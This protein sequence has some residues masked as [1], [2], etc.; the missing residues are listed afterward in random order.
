MRIAVS[1]M[2]TVMLC[3][4]AAAADTAAGPTPLQLY[5]A[6]KY[7]AAI[8]QGTASNAASGYAVA[9]RAELAVAQMRDKPCLECLKTA[10]GYARQSIALD[11]TLADG[12]VYLAAALGYESRIIGIMAAKFKGY[13]GEAKDNLD[14]ALAHHP[15]DPWVLA[16]LGGWHFAV[17]N[18]GG[19]TMANWMYGA[20]VKKGQDYYTK[21]FAADPPGIV[22]RYLYALSLSAYDREAYTKEIEAALAFAATGQPRTAYEMFMQGRAKTLL[23]AFKSGDWKAYNALVKRYQGYP[24]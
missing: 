6:G 17:V 21:A 13:A 12:H 1:A 23:A 4:G 15:D 14:V 16:A 7:A 2:L 3:A 19:A 22:I 11:P 24:Q 20:T 5:Q 10:E 9:A 8:Q 18:G